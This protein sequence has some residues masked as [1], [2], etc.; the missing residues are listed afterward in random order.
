MAREPF[1]WGQ[2]GAQLTPKQI[3]DR[4]K[5]AQ[6]LMAK[7]A[8]FSPAGHW[9]EA[10]GRAFNGWVGGRQAGEFNRQEEAGTA[11]ARAK[12]E[13]RYSGSPVAA[14]LAGSG[15]GGYV[16]PQR[17]P[18]SMGQD[19]EQ[20]LFA[21]EITPGGYAMGATLGGNPTTKEEFIAMIAPAAI[22]EGQR[23]GVDP[24]I[25]IAQA[26][27]ETGWGKSAP[28]NNYF[29]IK[30]HGKSG[31]G[32]FA[33]TEYIN[34]KPV[35]IVDSFRGYGSPEESVSGYASFL[36]ENPR[37]RPMLDAAGNFEAQIE[38]LGESGYATDP[39]YASSVRAIAQGID[40]SPYIGLSQSIPA[41][42]SSQEISALLADPWVAEQYGS[43]LGAELG[44]AQ[45]RENAI[46]QQQLAMQDPA[47][48]LG[49]ERQQLELDQ[50]R[51]PKVSEY[52]QRAQVGQQFGLQG[53]ALVNFALTGE[54]GSNVKP[55]GTIQEYEYYANGA[56]ARGEQP[57]PFEEYQAV[58]A[59]AGSGN[60]AGVGTVPAGYRLITD[61]LTGQV[62]GMEPIPGGPAELEA[63]KTA[64]SLESR[65]ANAANAA[66][67]VLQDI[68]K[69]INATGGWTAG[70]GGAVLGN[71]P[72]T[73]ATDL[74]ATIDT[75]KANIGFDR[76]QQMRD[77]SPT[78]GA[79][80]GI[81]VQE[82]N[83]L[84]AVLGSLDQAQSPEQLKANLQRLKE[85]YEPIAAKAAAYPN[86]GQYGFQGAA[87]D[88]PA[89]PKRMRYN[90]STGAFE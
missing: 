36:S 83:M 15:G 38:A 59:R 90:P 8:D 35:T 5:V 66:N 18:Y 34:G 42:T 85:V 69:A 23:I 10:L 47:Y 17:S 33:T 67:I 87:D 84:Q 2:G 79:L 75:V 52:D 81:A 60:P 16:P 76:L 63:E 21:N 72:G 55:T 73:G 12:M 29:G 7:G 80:G 44:A 27:Q 57:M 68:D 82:L 58:I 54:F 41:G 13:G 6:A 9:T 62:T 19:A 48:Q 64:A 45:S 49:L 56:A 89:A 40:L 14:A 53:D 11:A 78:G 77:A 74:R 65:E 28:N 88:T 26:A 4:R 61:P 37:Y 1:V 30:S 22:A 86:A 32:S 25:I 50:M 31:G 39:N 70:V 20:P 24:R 71:F 3:D 46:F 51:N 43:V